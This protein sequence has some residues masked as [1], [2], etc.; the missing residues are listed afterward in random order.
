[1]FVF[2]LYIVALI[3]NIDSVGNPK[4]ESVY[5]CV[6]QIC[7]RTCEST[8]S[9]AKKT[10]SVLLPILLDKGIVSNVAE[11]RTLRYDGFI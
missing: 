7:V 8:G 1:M 6:L 5:L 2:N 4:A 10:V 11:V 9:S 3:I